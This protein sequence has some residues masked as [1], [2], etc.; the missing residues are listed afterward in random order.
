MIKKLYQSL[1]DKLYFLEKNGI[2]HGLTTLLFMLLVWR[3][4][5]F[6]AA[7]GLA[8]IGCS[9]WYFYREY[10]AR[11]TFDIRQWYTDSQFDFITPLLVALI[12]CAARYP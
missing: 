11:K 2:A 9:V 4:V 7:V 10:R 5:P 6:Y 1:H 3:F 8:G 12:I